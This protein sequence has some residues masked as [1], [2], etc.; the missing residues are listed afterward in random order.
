MDIGEKI[1]RLRIQ[2]NLTQKELLTGLSYL[3]A[4]YHRLSK[5]TSPSI[6]TLIDI[7][8]CLVLI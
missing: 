2:N 8:E 7:L 3:K 4:L 1:K 6:A 5:S